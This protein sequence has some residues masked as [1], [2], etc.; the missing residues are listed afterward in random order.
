MASTIGTSVEDVEKQDQT[1]SSTP[2]TSPASSIIVDLEE[3]SPGYNVSQ[4]EKWL[5]VF[6]TSFMTLTACFS[7]TSLLSAAHIIADEFGT[8]TNV[9]NYSSAGLLFT[10]GLSSFGWGPL[11]PVCT[12]TS[13]RILAADIP[14]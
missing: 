11:I 13:H 8:D 4:V 5:V 6:T 10:M 3:N 9:I 14:S 12:N 7:S 1:P 2:T